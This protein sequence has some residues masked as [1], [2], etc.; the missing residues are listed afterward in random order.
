MANEE[1]LVPFKKGEDPRREGNGRPKGRKSLATIIRE[2]ENED[3]DWTII[4]KHGKEFQERF[5]HIGSP[6]KVITLV[7][8]LQAIRGSKDAR[9]WLR[10]SGYGDKLDLTSDGKKIESPL[11]VSVVKGRNVEPQAET[12]EGS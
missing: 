7:A 12:A 6:F 10:K 8:T 9:E 1:N 5:A 11:I 2:L 3:F 4:P